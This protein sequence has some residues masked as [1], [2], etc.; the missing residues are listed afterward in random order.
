MPSIL[1][2]IMTF[3]AYLGSQ[4]SQRPY[5]KGWG[6]HVNA[7]LC[8]T[9]RKAPNLVRPLWLLGACKVLAMLFS[10][11]RGKVWA[12]LPVGTCFFGTCLESGEETNAYFELLKAVPRKLKNNFLLCAVLQL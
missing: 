5:F 11:W 8:S 1:L 6:C 7:S 10:R 4:E 2:A 12:K 3:K 9:P